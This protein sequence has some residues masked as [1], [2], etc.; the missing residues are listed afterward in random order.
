MDD[1]TVAVGPSAAQ[2][3]TVRNGG[4]ASRA[5]FLRAVAAGGVAAATAS[6][7]GLDPPGADA[8]P[9]QV[10]DRAIFNFALLLEYLKD[11]FYSET[12]AHG[13]AR[14]ELREFV[15]VAGEHERA[16][17]QFLAHTL[18]KHARKR[19]TFDFGESTRRRPAFLR[20]ARALE[21]LAVAA[22]NGQAANLTPSGLAAAVRI[23][24]V[25]G[26]HAA[27]IRALAGDDP[28]PRAADPG[29]GAAD[30]EAALRRLHIR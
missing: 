10:Q 16:H 22:Y 7:Y 27:W 24:S 5:G 28:A 15:A 11:S 26:R 29:Q 20:T 23:V 14:G 3:A 13:W 2:E 9:S 1:E 17:A 4:L 12:L 18:G 30:V 25:E 19:P 21:D 8:R 6:W